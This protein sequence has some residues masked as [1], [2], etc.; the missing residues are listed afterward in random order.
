METCTAPAC[1]GTGEC[2]PSSEMEHSISQFGIFERDG[3]GSFRYEGDAFSH[4]QF[5]HR[6][7]EGLYT[8]AVPST[9]SRYCTLSETMGAIESVT[10]GQ[11]PTRYCYRRPL[12]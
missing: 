10:G 4:G 5:H 11:P 1:Q 3:T 9:R 6:A 7:A 2:W 12:M 8:C